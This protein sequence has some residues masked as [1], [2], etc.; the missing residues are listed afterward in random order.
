M[1]P[2]LTIGYLDDSWFLRIQLTGRWPG[3][4]EC[5]FVRSGWTWP[6]SHTPFYC[7]VS[8]DR[9]K[10]I[11]HL[12]GSLPVNWIWRNQERAVQ[13]DLRD[14]EITYCYAW[15][16]KQKITTLVMNVVMPPQESGWLWTLLHGSTISPRPTLSKCQIRMVDFG[17]F[18]RF[19][20]LGFIFDKNYGLVFVPIGFGLQI[21]LKIP[22]LDH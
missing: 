6:R 10:R 11:P 18:Y 5:A 17:F 7:F 22:R 16:G 9:K 3:V 21:L 2:S 12:L 14:I 19:V 15:G 13:I 4:E 8:E 20:W 1:K